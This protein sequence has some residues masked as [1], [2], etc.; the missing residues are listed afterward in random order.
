MLERMTCVEV[1]Q[2]F[3][4]NTRTVLETA[5]AKLVFEITCSGVYLDNWPSG[6]SES[7]CLWWHS[8]G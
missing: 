3:F 8:G 6:G 1:E 7:R 2:T 4:Y 5:G